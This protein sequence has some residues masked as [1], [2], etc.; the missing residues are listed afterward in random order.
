MP[1]WKQAIRAHLVAAKLDPFTEIELIEELEQHLEDR[2]QELRATGVD[3]DE[4]WRSTVAEL[5]G[6]ELLVRAARMARRSPPRRRAI[7]VQA[8]KGEFMHGSLHDLKIALRNLRTKPSF[9]LMVIG[10]LAVGI[11]GNAAMFSIFNSLFLRPLPFAES[12]KLVD[13]DETAPKWNLKYVGVTSSDCFE[14]SK[15][16]ETLEAMAFFRGSS[17]NF[18]D[19]GTAQRVQGA[20]VGREMLDVLRLTPLLGRNFTPEEDRPGG[21]KVVM[22]GYGL[23]RRLF[24]G[25]RNML[26]RVV[27][28]DDEAYTIIGVLPREA[29][30]PDLAE[31]WIPLAANPTVP[32]GYYLSGVGRLRSG[33]SIEQAWAD[34][35]RIHK[36][37]ISGGHSENEFTS[38]VVTPLRDR[39]LGDFKVVS[40]VLLGAVGLVLLITCANIAALMLVRSSFRSRE[41]AIRA[42]LGASRARIVTQLLT[43]SAVLAAIG[44]VLGVSLGAVCLRAMVSLMSE[45][46]PRWISFSLDGRF[47]IFCIAISGAA[48][49]LFGLAPALQASRSDI[50]GPLQNTASRTTPPRGERVM[51]SGFVVCEIALALMLSI[52]AGLLVQ[53]FRKVLQV[54]PGFR[55]ENALTFRTSV[56]ETTYDMPEKK[57][58]YYDKLLDRLRS[59]PGVRAAGA[60]S[61]LPFGGQWG[62]QFEAEGGVVRAP[63]ENPVVLRVAATPGYVE[64]MGMTLLD[65][66]TFEQQDGRPNSRLVVLVNETF[67]KHFWG[68]GSPLGKRIRYPGTKD[69]FEVIGFLR[70]EKHYGLDQEMKPGVFL[71]YAEAAFI[72]DKNDARAFQQ[73]SIVLRS[74]IDPKTLINPATEVLRQLD[75]EVPMYAAD[76]MTEKLDRSLWARRTYSWLFGAF[77]VMAILLAAAGVYGTISYAVSRRTQEIGIRMAL[78]ARP[79]QVLRQVL[80]GGMTIV[81]IGVPAGLAGALWATRLLR[82]LLF[83][84]DTHDPLIY[85]GVVLGVIGVAL[86]ANVVP[87][88]RAAGVDPLCALR[89]E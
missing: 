78:G 5:D 24:G 76:T 74:F 13:L 82:R 44:G 81:L 14:W 40:Q 69:W 58:A 85:A 20:Q 1:D 39:Y 72:S 67:A 16:N 28:L 62:G 9:S 19:G 21:A 38:P 88:R 17:Y 26:G 27:K 31:L 70:D 75:P 55:P 35:L 54:D 45:Q 30:F 33:V 37:M 77:A 36:A 23:W 60:T 10:L 15:G 18:S 59:L 65:G 25:D 80:L 41:F 66:R 57:V 47:A 56:P 42:A 89:F 34:L 12:D 64:A 8:S 84:V 49:V 46:V 7:G 63:N 48:A 86:L 43:E 29:V 53:S 6:A 52:S 22:L 50:R 83:S 61:S 68:N 4:G 2:Y 51:L 71:P 87:A 32:S 11:A 73:M 79:G 3:E